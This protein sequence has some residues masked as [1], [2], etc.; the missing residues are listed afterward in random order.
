MNRTARA[1]PV[2]ALVVLPAAAQAQTATPPQENYSLRLEYR[3]YR[4][5]FDGEIQKGF[6]DD[7]GTVLDIVD[8]LGIEDERTF[9]ARVTFQLKPGHK[10]R[11]SYTPL[12]YAGSVESARRGFQYGQLDVDFG[13]PVETRMKGTYWSGAYEFDFVRGPKGFLGGTLGAKFVDIDTTIVAVNDGQ[14]ELDEWQSPVPALGLISRVYVGRV[15]LEGEISGFTLG[16]RGS[17]IEF[18]ASARI[19][20]S[21]RLAAEGGYRYLKI[22]GEDDRDFGD[23]SLSGW[24]FGLELSL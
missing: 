7:A 17:L 18:D 14:R 15:S 11:G 2:A 16:D 21:D 24:H 3:E 4:P 9:E 22:R 5:E 23:V 19:H 10:L 6:G 8:D 1:L 13:E 12:D 20:F